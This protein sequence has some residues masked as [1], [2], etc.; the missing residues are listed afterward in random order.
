MAIST[1]EA[2]TLMKK[3]NLTDFESNLFLEY[4][5]KQLEKEIEKRDAKILQQSKVLNV[6]Q[7]NIGTLKEALNTNGLSLYNQIR[8]LKIE[9]TKLTTIKK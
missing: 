8:K 6:L 4:H 1:N 9:I 5:I 2:I 7:N 3:G